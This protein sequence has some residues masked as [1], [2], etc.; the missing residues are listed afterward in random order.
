MKRAAMKRGP[1]E[2]PREP[3]VEVDHDVMERLNAAFE[4]N[5]TLTVAQVLDAMVDPAASPTERASQRARFK[6]LLTPILR[7]VLRRRRP[8]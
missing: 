7:H 4:G 1:C 6:A 3:H 5:E 2:L 8:R